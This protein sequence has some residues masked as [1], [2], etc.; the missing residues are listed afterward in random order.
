MPAP[1]VP[2]PVAVALLNS[3]VPPLTNTS[4]VKA[5]GPVRIVV[6]VPDTTRRVIP[7]VPAKSLMPELMV[8]APVE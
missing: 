7:V 8:K 2:E 5:I 3:R 1:S 4:P 6:P